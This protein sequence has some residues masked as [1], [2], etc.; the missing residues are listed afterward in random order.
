MTGRELII[1]ILENGLEDELVFKDG[2]FI[3]FIT[4][5]EAAAKMNV[6]SATVNAFILQN[7]IESVPVV[8]GV[9]IPANFKS[10]IKEVK[11]NG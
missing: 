10:P 2:K 3:G 9:Y 4:I 7:K 1:Y 5:G 11:N 6:G 8:S